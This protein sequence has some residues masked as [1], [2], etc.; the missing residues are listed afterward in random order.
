MKYKKYHWRNS[1]KIIERDKIDTSNTQIHDLSLSWLDTSNTQ[2]HDLSLS[3]LDTSNT[4]IHDLSLSWLHFNKKRQVKLVLI[5]SFWKCNVW[6]LSN[7]FIIPPQTKFGGY[8]G[9]TLSVRPSV[10]PS[11]RLSMYLVSA[12]PPKRLIGFLWN[13]HICSTLPAD[14]HEGIWMLSKI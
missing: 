13:L 10:H 11:V 14:V 3:W 8:I 9:I 6:W 12:T 1:S 7:Y 2:I 4:Q 5:G